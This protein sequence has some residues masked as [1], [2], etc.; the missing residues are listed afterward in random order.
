MFNV[1]LPGEIH[2]LKKERKINV[3]WKKKKRIF[4]QE[5]TYSVMKNVKKY[6][7]CHIFVFSKEVCY[8]TA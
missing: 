1:C 7:F 6:F 5:N 4:I 3:H 2:C 8:W